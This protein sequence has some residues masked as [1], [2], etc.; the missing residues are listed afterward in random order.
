MLKIFLSPLQA[1]LEGYLVNII[2]PV[3]DLFIPLCCCFY[4]PFLLTK[5]SKASTTLCPFAFEALH[6]VQAGHKMYFC[7]L[8]S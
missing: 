7:L 2:W 1:F 6:S 4:Y 5:D 3:P 8:L